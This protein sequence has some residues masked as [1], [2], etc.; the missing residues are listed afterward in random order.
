MR[1]IHTALLVAALSFTAAP[2]AFA[3]G[4]DSD[5]L[6]VT[7]SVENSCVITGGTLAF[8]VYDTITGAA[9]D[10]STAIRVECTAGATATITLGEGANADVGSTA[11]DPE[12]RLSDGGSSFLAYELFID[13]N[14]GSEWG[15]TLGTGKEYT[16]VDANPAAQTVYGRITS[17]QDVAAGAYADTVVAT[18]TF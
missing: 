18:V 8:G 5:N 15:D 4:S 7:A 2:S 10:A 17:G 9:V 3:A 13:S 6:T 16:A 1:S 12:R 14:R 11:D